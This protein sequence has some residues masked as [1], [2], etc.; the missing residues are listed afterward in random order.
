MLVRRTLH[1][2][3]NQKMTQIQTTLSDLYSSNCSLYFWYTRC[4][5]SCC[6]ISKVR[7]R[8]KTESKGF[9]HDCQC[10]FRLLFLFCYHAHSCVFVFIGWNDHGWLCLDDLS[11]HCYAINVTFQKQTGRNI[12]AAYLDIWKQFCAMW[13]IKQFLPHY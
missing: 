1:A 12:T 5:G 10:Y 9:S 13:N 2:N 4:Y 7:V 3:K 11:S 8:Y 6:N